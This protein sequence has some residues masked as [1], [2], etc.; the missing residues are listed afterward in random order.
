MKNKI[1]TITV[2]TSL[3][4][5]TTG[6]QS[7][8]GG[9]NEEVA[10]KNIVVNPIDISKIENKEFKL[11]YLNNK[12]MSYEINTPTINF[13][14]DKDLGNVISGNTGCNKYYAPYE[15]KKSF[16]ITGQIGTTMQM[17]SPEEMETESMMINVLTG[18]PFILFEKDTII[19]KIAGNELKFE[20]LS[21][22]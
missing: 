3:L 21:K 4:L 6:C 16:L 22:K 8:S 2:I 17:C 5:A 9:A 13:I 11:T 15:T 20:E 14:K 18:R 12:K 1:K 7:F 10:N 19:L